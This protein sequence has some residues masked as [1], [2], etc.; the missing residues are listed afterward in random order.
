[1]QW[2]IPDLAPGEVE[3]IDYDVRVTMD[4][5]YVNLLH[6]DATAVDGTGYATMD[7]AAYI[8]VRSTGVAPKTTRYDGWQP[9]D[10][11]MTSPDQGITIDLSPDEDLV[12]SDEEQSGTES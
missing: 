1:M 7:A 4:G 5:S 6:V 9:P 2:V 10:W 3:T 12:E 8:D 11:N